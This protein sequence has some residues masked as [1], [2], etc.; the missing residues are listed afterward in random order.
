[1]NRA[2]RRP[3][4]LRLPR[5]PRFVRA[6]RERAA[7]RAVAASHVSPLDLAEEALA[8][9][10]A[11]PGRAALTVVAIVIGLAALVATLGISRTA[12]N[13]IVGQ[14]DE[15]AATEILVR[16]R[17]QPANAAPITIPWDADERLARLNGVVAAG[18]LSAVDI[19]TALV[20]TSQLSDPQRQTDFRLTVEA[21][22]PSLLG[23]VRGQLSSGRWIDA[24]DSARAERVAVLGATAALR[25][26]LQ[27]VA[28]LP[29][30]A[31]GD[32][33]YLV[34]GILERVARRPEMLGAVII[35]EGTARREF[36]L[37]S[38]SSSSWR[39]RSA[40]TS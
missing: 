8:G 10:F 3:A 35:P 12:G 6:P 19:G 13:R 21:A 20:R 34:I 31:I 11:R 40:P 29:A 5:R 1:M 39:P 17:P 2:W 14:F 36:R 23:A 38:R 26:G 25:L 7:V 28:N 33:I 30:I 16:A 18:T 32:D 4:P 27:D 24:S 37:D 15:L 9:L 22:S